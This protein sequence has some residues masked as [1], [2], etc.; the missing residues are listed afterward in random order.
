MPRQRRAAA[1]ETVDAARLRASRNYAQVLREV[2]GID[3]VDDNALPQRRKADR[4]RTLAIVTGDERAGSKPASA[5]SRAAVEQLRGMGWH[6]YP[7]CARRKV[8]ASNVLGTDAARAEVVANG[9]LNEIVERFCDIS[10][11]HSLGRMAKSR[12]GR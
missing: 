6:R 3:P 9:G 1:D 8:V 11:S 12:V 7:R 5:N 4:Q 2:I 10:L